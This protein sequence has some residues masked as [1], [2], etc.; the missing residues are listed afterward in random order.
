M[1]I[2][3]KHYISFSAHTGTHIQY[4]QWSWTIYASRH[5]R[6]KWNNLLKQ[7]FCI[8][9]SPPS[10][11]NNARVSYLQKCIQMPSLALICK[12]FYVC[13]WFSSWMHFPL[14]FNTGAVGVLQC[15]PAECRSSSCGCHC[16]HA[17]QQKAADCLIRMR[18]EP[19]ENRIWLTLMLQI[20]SGKIP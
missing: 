8:Y 10:E 15:R 5:L 20:D 7:T 4:I 19:R 17:R 12:I 3:N 11:D 16:M 6:R 9:I 2:Q 14:L 18:G 13:L 1:N